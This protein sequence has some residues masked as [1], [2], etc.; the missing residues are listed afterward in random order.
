MRLGLFE[1]S[2]ALGVWHPRSGAVAL[3]D[4]SQERCHL[5]VGM[6]SSPHGVFDV[7]LFAD[8]HVFEAIGVADAAL[9]REQA[10][11]RL[12]RNAAPAVG[13]DEG[14]RLLAVCRRDVRR[15]RV[16]A[17]TPCP[18][19][20]Q[21]MTDNTAKGVAANGVPL[22]SLAYRAGIC[23]A[24]RYARPPRRTSRSRRP[25]A[26]GRPVDSRGGL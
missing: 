26:S 1:P 7:G 2:D 15:K 9:E 23:I 17:S 20:P 11:D 13:A 16:H 4:V 21:A 24:E 25:K 18:L 6:H 8:D 22:C 3:A 5:R 10:V 14:G 19:V 12:Y